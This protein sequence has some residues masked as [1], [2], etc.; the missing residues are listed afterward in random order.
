M[1]E[2][3]LLTEAVMA[4]DEQKVSTLVQA[5]LDRNVAPG[6]ILSGGLIAGM[7]LVGEKMEQGEMF[8]P[9]VLMAAHAMSS[10]MKLLKPLLGVA[11]GAA[12]GRVVIGTVR[13]DL[14]DIGKNLVAMMIESTGMDV[15]NLGVDIPPETFVEE[16]RN[17]GAD[18]L[19]LSAMLTTTMQMMKKTIEAVTA[20][21]LRDG[22]KIMVGGSPVSKEFAAMIG[23][24]GYAPD[25]RSA[26]RMA[27]AFVGV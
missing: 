22:V 7:D 20:A 24:D 19:C 21:G 6:E 15:H 5:A 18:L 17:R 14:H 23:A 16:V 3:N 1:F 4:G 27:R 10:G 9:E 12:K 8:I 25:D 11:G 2:S 13:G 26:A